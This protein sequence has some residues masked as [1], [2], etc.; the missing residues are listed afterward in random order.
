MTT[1]ESLAKLPTTLSSLQTIEALIFSYA[2]L[3]DA[4]DFAAVGALFADATFLGSGATH[5]G[6]AAVEK[7]LVDAVAT[8]DDGTPRTKHV[9]TNLVI[10]VDERAGT[11]EARSCVTVMQALSTFPL[12]TILSGRYFDRFERRGERWRFTERRLKFDLVG[13]VSHHLRAK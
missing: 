4:G 6:Q 11:A 3:V 2:E 7:M 9:V 13:D 12:Q 1:D 8:Y 5:K 10:T